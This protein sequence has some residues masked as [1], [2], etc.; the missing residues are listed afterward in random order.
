MWVA[1]KHILSPGVGYIVFTLNWI[2]ENENV[3]TLLIILYRNIP[4]RC[5]QKWWAWIRVSGCFHQQIKKHKPQV[6][7]FAYLLSF[8]PLLHLVFS[9]CISNL[10]DSLALQDIRGSD[11]E[12]QQWACGY[13]SSLSCYEK[14]TSVFYAP[15]WIIKLITSS[16]YTSTKAKFLTTGRNLWISLYS[17]KT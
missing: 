15:D 7:K 9:L 14:T 11:T 3:I 6:W 5:K 12:T 4:N 1:L 17:P 10:D 2:N 13:C 8:I 16:N